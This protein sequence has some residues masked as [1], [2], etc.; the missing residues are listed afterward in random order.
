[1]RVV[2]IRFLIVLAIVCE[3]DHS[4]ISNSSLS[5]R[6]QKRALFSPV[7]LYPYNACSGILVAIA[8]PLVDIDHNVFVSYNFEAN[9][10][11]PNV[12]SDSIPGPLKRIP[13]LVPEDTSL[14]ESERKFSS[15]STAIEERKIGTKIQLTRKGV[16]QMIESR[17]RSMGFDGKKCWLRAICDA[18]THSFL[19]SN[20]VLGHIIHVLLT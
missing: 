17:L 5:R 11:M 12:P 14:P 4:E 9:Y 3:S 1:M 15:N 13:G 6:L 19:E 16:Y 8:V 10:N 20:G 7:L 2:V 18:S